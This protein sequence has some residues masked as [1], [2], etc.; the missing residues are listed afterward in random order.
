MS[1]EITN[2]Y[3]IDTETLYISPKEAAEIGKDYAEKYREWKL[4]HYIGID[5]FLSVEVIAKL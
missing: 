2:P 4:Y 1:L 3:P 5:D